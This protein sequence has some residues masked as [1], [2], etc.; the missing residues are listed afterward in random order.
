M[1][2]EIKINNNT[3]VL[4]I[5]GDFSEAILTLNGRPIQFTW[6]AEIGTTWRY[7]LAKGLTKSPFIRKTHIEKILYD[8]ISDVSQVDSVIRYYKSFLMTGYYAFGTY[9]LPKHLELRQALRS[10][11]TEFD[12]YGGVSGLIGTQINI[13]SKLVDSYKEQ[14]LKGKRP[15]MVIFRNKDSHTQF[16][17][18]GHHKFLGYQ[19][20]KIP[21]QAIIITKLNPTSLSVQDSLKVLKKM[22][23]TNIDYPIKLKEE[24]KN[25]FFDL[26]LDIEK[27]YEEFLI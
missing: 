20:T 17:L 24:K 7:H 15:C 10:D 19:K 1:K 8:G 26:K 27:C 22:K 25:S 6:F 4:D 14:I 13:N 2:K 23:S 16:I 9:V 5:K 12:D 11:Y 3:G 18:D 21:P